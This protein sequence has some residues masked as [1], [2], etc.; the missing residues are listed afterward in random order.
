MRVITS[1]THLIQKVFIK[2]QL[3]SNVL[4]VTSVFA[5][6]RAIEPMLFV[7]VTSIVLAK[8]SFLADFLFS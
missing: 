4:I 3:L 6:I 5:H 1:Q 8:S 7:N 2:I